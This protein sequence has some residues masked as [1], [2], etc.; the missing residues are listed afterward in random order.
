MCILITQFFCRLLKLPC[1]FSCTSFH[2]TDIQGVFK[3][4]SLNFFIISQVFAK[5]NIFFCNRRHQTCQVLMIYLLKLFFFSCLHA[6]FYDLSIP[7]AFCTDQTNQKPNKIFEVVFSNL[8][9][10]VFMFF[11]VLTMCLL[12]L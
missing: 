9:K 6:C 11:Y 8:I 5:S 2:I 10:I 4:C 3:T 7:T 1:S 12:K